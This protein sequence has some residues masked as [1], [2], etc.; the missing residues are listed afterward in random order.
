MFVAAALLGALFTSAP[1]SAAPGG[2]AGA[3][4][5]PPSGGLCGGAV[6]V[7]VVGT[8]VTGDEWQFATVA[9]I[10]PSGPCTFVVAAVVASGTW[11][12]AGGGCVGSPTGSVCVTAVPTP[13]TPTNA[14]VTVCPALLG[15]CVS[16]QA[17][18]VRA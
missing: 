13:L 6:A 11:H 16:A 3:G 2:L 17:T 5:G 15:G 12:P 8:N 7:T 14:T 18:V 9:V 10:N 4:A 1:A